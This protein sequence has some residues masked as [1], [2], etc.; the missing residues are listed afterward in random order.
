MRPWRPRHAAAA[1][2]AVA[3]TALGVPAHASADAAWAALKAGGH[4]LIVRHA[5]TVPGVGDPPQFRRDDCATQRNLSEAGREQSRSMGR[6][7]RE[8]GVAIGPVLS[9]AWCRCVD[10]AELAFGRVERYAP[11]DSFFGDRSREAAQT[12]A[13]R[14]RIRSHRG[15]GTLVLVTHQVNITALTGEGPAMGEALVLAPAGPAGFVPV[16][17]I[18]F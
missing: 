7:L 14:E 10:T 13:L 17:R 9:S 16:G 2:L 12:A 8:A 15:P 6:R 5:Q 11:L 1:L 18:P 4:V 3:A